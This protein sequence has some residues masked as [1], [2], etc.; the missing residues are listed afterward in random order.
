MMQPVVILT[1][2]LQDADTVLL[3]LR[4]VAR[5]CGN[6]TSSND[7]LESA[8]DALQADISTVT[9]ARDRLLRNCGVKESGAT[10]TGSGA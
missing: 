7:V 5:F 1:I 6:G 8:A 4:S 9:A 10:G 3:A 2:P